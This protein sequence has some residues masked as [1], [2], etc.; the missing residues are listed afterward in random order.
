MKLASIL[1]I[2]LVTAQG[3]Q[4]VPPKQEQI[5]LKVVSDD[6]S[7]KLIYFTSSLGT[8]GYVCSGFT[9]NEPDLL[10]PTIRVIPR[11]KSYY[12]PINIW[13]ADLFD[14]NQNPIYI[15][16]EDALEKLSAINTLYVDWSRVTKPVSKY[17][18]YY[19]NSIV[20]QFIEDCFDDYKKDRINFIK[21][22]QEQIREENLRAE[23]HKKDVHY[24]V[25]NALKKN[26]IPGA[27][28]GGE[29]IIHNV[30]FEKRY[31]DKA[32]YRQFL[33]SKNTAYWVDFSQYVVKQS[34]GNSHYVL[35]HIIEDY[36]APAIVPPLPIM[37]KTKSQLIEGDTPNRSVALYTGVKLYQ[38]ISGTN[39]QLVSFTSLD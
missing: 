37:L 33:N 16:Q 13:M 2:T 31:K 34:L 39:K 19:D 18:L 11:S 4:L 22:I 25:E 10:Q 17:E 29:L 14:L 6:M 23:Q 24:S 21:R 35:R 5:D 38:T 9:S 26:N 1:A 8:F 36:Y 15:K 3:C 32:G 27:G 7:N 28:N 12:R 30:L 20:N